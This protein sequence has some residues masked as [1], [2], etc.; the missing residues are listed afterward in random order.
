MIQNEDSLIQNKD[1]ERKEERTVEDKLDE[2]RAASNLVS[3]ASEIPPSLGAVAKRRSPRNKQK[4][5]TDR[6]E[7]KQTAKTV[8]S[9]R[10]GQEA[11]DFLRR[12]VQMQMDHV[13]GAIFSHLSS[14]DLCRIAQVRSPLSS[15]SSL[16]VTFL[17]ARFPPPGR[18][19]CRAAR[20]R[21]TGDWPSYPI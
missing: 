2:A 21:T 14:L 7:R 9:S 11:C 1:E 8:R 20:A 13:L 15:L 18:R 4:P 16:I 10:E 6:L 17:L 12:F 3:S 5:S 19:P